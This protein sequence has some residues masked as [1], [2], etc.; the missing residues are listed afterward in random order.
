MDKIHQ[1][2]SKGKKQGYIL[3]EKIDKTF[4]DSVDDG[5]NFNEFINS[6]D[7]HGIKILYK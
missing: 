7:S 4:K 3:F 5:K 6:I 2:F 1:L